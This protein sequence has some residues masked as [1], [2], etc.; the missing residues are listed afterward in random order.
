MF[1]KEYNV[2]TIDLMYI[3]HLNGA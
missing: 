2:S 3:I 1:S